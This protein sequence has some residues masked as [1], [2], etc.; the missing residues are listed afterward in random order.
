MLSVCSLSSIPLTTTTNRFLL[1]TQVVFNPFVWLP[2]GILL[3]V[4]VFRG[5]IRGGWEITGC[6]L[7]PILLAHL[8]AYPYRSWAERTFRKRFS[9]KFEKGG[10]PPSLIAHSFG[11][12]LS[13]RA[14]RDL[15]WARFN[16]IALA[17]CV[18]AA[19]FPW[20]TNSGIESV[21]V[22][23]GAQRDGCTRRLP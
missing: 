17:G 20:S 15:P 19:E 6:V 14:L 10:A 18:L 2:F 5:W 8:A 3:A 4:A 13:G 11:T 7:S 21:P 9:K 16:R 22:L 1:G 23:R 12:Y